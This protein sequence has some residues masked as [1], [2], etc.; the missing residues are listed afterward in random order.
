MLWL[1]DKDST[2]TTLRYVIADTF[3][4]TVDGSEERAV[5]LR[6]LAHK[7]IKETLSEKGFGPLARWRFLKL[8]SDD[9]EREVQQVLR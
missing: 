9:I 1:K 6:E 3:A 2:L 8:V 5:Y 4:T 7:R